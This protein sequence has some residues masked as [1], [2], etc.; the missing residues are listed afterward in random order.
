MRFALTTQISNAI[1][2]VGI[3]PK[4][5]FALIAIGNVTI[6]QSICDDL[7]SELKNI[8]SKNYDLSLIRHFKITKNEL[9]SVYSKTPLEDILVEKA[10]VLF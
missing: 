5:D 1:K 4:K 9:D 6:P 10:S 2:I 3:K 8:F 7:S